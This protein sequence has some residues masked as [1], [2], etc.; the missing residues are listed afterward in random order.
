MPDLN[1]T[2]N[3]HFT[4][5]LHVVTLNNEY[6]EDAWQ[7]HARNFI[8]DINPI[9][10]VKSF[11]LFRRLFKVENQVRFQDFCRLLYLHL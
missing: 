2:H 8:E 11:I 4:R 1:A 5:L 10:S 6:I 7:S 3:Y 9:E